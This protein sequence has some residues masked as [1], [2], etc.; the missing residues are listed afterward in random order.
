MQQFRVAVVGA[1]VI[2]SPV[3]LYELYA[4]ARPGLT[5]SESGILRIALLFGLFFFCLGLLFAY[6]IALPFMLNFLISL[7]YDQALQESIKAS[8]SIASYLD[9]VLLMFI[10][11]GC[12]FE[13]PLISVVLSRLGLLTPKMMNSLR[14]YAIIVIFIVAAIVTPP[15]VASQIMVAVPM[16]LLYLL[17]TLLCKIFYKNLSGAGK[18]AGLR[19]RT[20]APRPANPRH[21]F[22]PASGHSKM[23]GH[24]RQRDLRRGLQRGL[25]SKPPEGRTGR[26]AGAAERGELPV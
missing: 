1:L 22:R 19:G 15:D 18:A 13:M 12:M 4:F 5:K 7:Q 23:G 21:G 3:I 6:F 26:A 2:A 16:I 17:S 8:I 20:V 24:G 10:I 25:L 14:P 11:F 9:F